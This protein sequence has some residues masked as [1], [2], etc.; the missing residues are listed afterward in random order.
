MLR[1]S[2]K[3]LFITIERERY[4]NN[5]LKLW[6]RKSD[7]KYLFIITDFQPYFYMKA[8]DRHLLREVPKL[9]I[10]GVTEG[11]NSLF[12]EPL[13]RVYV[14]IPKNVQEIRK[15]NLFTMMEA[16]II[17]QRRF[18]IDKGIKSHFIAPSP[19]FNER[20]IYCETKDIQGV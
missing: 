4:D 6:G 11:F 16:D 2:E 9:D 17:F 14:R 13:L 15:M 19:N 7:G 8:E 1:Q 18:I 20:V 3:Y 10:V 12:D 5:V